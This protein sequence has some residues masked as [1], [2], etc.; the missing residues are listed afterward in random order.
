[1][2][3]ENDFTLE[4]L[5]RLSKAY[6]ECKLSRLQEKELELVLYCT[7]KS[8]PVID[9]VRRTMG[10][11]SL[12]S[13]AQAKSVASKF[14]RH[15]RK[16]A[17]KFIVAVACASILA[18]SAVFVGLVLRRPGNIPTHDTISVFV[19]GRELTGEMARTT[20][21][22][23]QNFSMEMLNSVLDDAD[24]VQNQSVENMNEIINNS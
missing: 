12:I 20:A 11:I 23:T 18:V 13:E 19:D 14:L 4:E 9:E 17:W 16:R 24:R 7:G 2:S 22:N 15:K 8:S 1:M 5:E 6:L 10:F 21:I 3:T